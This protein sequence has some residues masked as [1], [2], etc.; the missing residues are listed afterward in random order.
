[1]NFSLAA[2]LATRVELLLFASGDA[3]E[4]MRVVELDGHHRS[5]DHWHV[6]VEGVGIG[7]CYAYRVF[8]PL[9]P[10]RHGFNPS[11]LLLDPCARAITGWNVYRRVDALGA[12]PNTASCLKGVVTERDRFDFAAAPRPRHS[13]QRTVI[14][15]LHVGGFSRGRGS[16]V[17]PE[18]QGT[19]LGL[20][21]AIP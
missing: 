18:T 15:E 8:G 19:Y 1:M 7:C 20:I 9:Q 21:E 17:R 10:G 16:P 5:G 3:P 14:Y 6:E 2:P 11:K 13:W 4:P 12:T